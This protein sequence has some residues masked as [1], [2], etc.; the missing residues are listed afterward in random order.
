MERTWLK[1][2]RYS[3]GYTH[4]NVADDCNVTRAYYTQI[5]SGIRTPSVFVAKKIAK[6]LK[7]NWTIFFKEISNVSKQK[8]SDPTLAA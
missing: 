8:N 7:F 2:I 5:E 1:N 3:L 4:Q 6:K